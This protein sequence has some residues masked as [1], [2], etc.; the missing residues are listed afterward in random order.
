MTAEKEGKLFCHLCKGSWDTPRPEAHNAEGHLEECFTNP[1]TREPY[2]LPPG[3]KEALIHL[4]T[5]YPNMPG[6][7]CDPMYFAN[8]IARNMGFGDGASNFHHNLQ[9]E[10]K[11]DDEGHELAIIQLT[12]EGVIAD[13]FINGVE[14]GTWAATAQEIVELML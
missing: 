11:L 7:L 13:T 14:S 4:F 12:E 1:T 9:R 8:V 2:D 3:L 10:Y 6:G 5:V